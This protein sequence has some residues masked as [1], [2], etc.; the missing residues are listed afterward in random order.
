[1]VDPPGRMNPKVVETWLSDTIRQAEDMNIPGTILKQDNT[2]PL[3]WFG[4]DRA[5]LGSNGIQEETINR[6]YR[7]LFVYSVGFHE[8]LKRTTS[9]AT[10]RYMI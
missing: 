4:I 1:M 8:L 6:I 9:H 5:T 2:T 10:N 7:A 3:K